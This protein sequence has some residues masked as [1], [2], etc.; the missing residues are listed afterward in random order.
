MSVEIRKDKFGPLDLHFAPGDGVMMV[1]AV[2]TTSTPKKEPQQVIKRLDT[3]DDK[4]AYWGGNNQ[5]PQEVVKDIEQSDLLGPALEKKAGMLYS[6]GL[7]YGRK[8]IDENGV[9]QI[10]PFVDPEI[11]DWLRYTNSQLFN[12]DMCSDHFTFYNCFPRFMLTADRKRIAR[13]EVA[14]ATSV[15]LG[16]Q[17]NK[18]RI[19]KAYLN[20]DWSAAERKDDIPID[21]LSLYNIPQQ[22]KAGKAHEYIL[23]L[24]QQKNGRIYYQLAPW[25]G[26]RANG[27]LEV[28]KAIPEF[29]KFLMQNQMTIKLVIK[30]D[31]DYWPALFK[32]GEWEKKKLS[33]KQSF[34]KDFFTQLVKD[35]KGNEKAGGFV[36]IP[37]K[38]QETA[39][40][41][42]YREYISV[43]P[44]GQ[45]FKGGEYL[46]DSQEADFHIM[47]AIGVPPTLMGITPG[48]GHNS[49]SGSDQR[50]AR[51]NFVLDSKMDMERIL[52][53]YDIVSE[54]NGWNERFGKGGRLAW[55]FENYYVA[56]LDSGNDIQE[57]QEKANGDS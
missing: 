47:R 21:A 8:V 51:N 5:F 55:W 17:D 45:A 27:W 37:K 28:A 6:G 20:A 41:S 46:E 29:K 15:R 22:I 48:K 34:K 52:T 4:I 24:R 7:V 42:E 39:R 26:L 49:G 13:M 18:G 11:D 23:P 31:Q 16:R 36:H 38:W 12:Q 57:T 1:E 54:Y 14:D 40:G 3:Q 56:T 30:V 50:V 25:N 9:R 53:P 35:M 33:E 44:F 43:E 32:E 2:P 10:E 19:N